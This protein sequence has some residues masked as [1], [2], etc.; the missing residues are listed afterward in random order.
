MEDIVKII[1]HI[2]TDFPEKFGIPRQSGLHRGLSVIEFEKEY[3]TDE[4]L[5]GIEGYSHLWLIW[6]FSKAER[7]GWSPTVRPPRLGGNIRMGVFATRSPFRPNPIGLSSVELCKV[8][9]TENGSVLVVRGAD[10]ANGTPIYDIKPYLAFTDS[11]PNARGGFSDEK[12]DYRLSVEIPNEL[13]LLLPEEKRPILAEIL[14]QDPRPAYIDDPE[15]IYGFP[16]AG[17]E[18]RFRV[19][20]GDLF[21]TE[22]RKSMSEN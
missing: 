19:C 10:L 20:G 22:V 8:K 13:L 5:R 6:K 14:E 18:I 12:R 16:F 15:R 2:R 1:A 17:F 3:R 7:K 4:A 11:H 9:K 21:V